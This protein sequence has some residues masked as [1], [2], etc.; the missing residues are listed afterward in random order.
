MACITGVEATSDDLP[1]AWLGPPRKQLS[2]EELARRSAIAWDIP[3]AAL[4]RLFARNGGSLYSRSVYLAGTELY[5]EVNLSREASTGPYSLH[6]YMGLDDCTLYGQTDEPLPRVLVCTCV[7]QY[8]APGKS[9]LQEI[10]TFS[11]ALAEEAG[12]GYG[13]VF[14]ASSP[15][16]LVPHLVDGCLKLR[17]HI[18]KVM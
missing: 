5:L 12:R 9:A 15:S 8:L 11:T 18:E 4:E 1:P 14:T 16:D 13:W 6:I 7:M 3:F 17:A 10:G 2:A